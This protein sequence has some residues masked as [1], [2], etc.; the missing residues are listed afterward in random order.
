VS[1]APQAVKRL[2]VECSG[3]CRR[4]TKK[5]ARCFTSSC[6][7][8]TTN[9]RSG[10]RSATPSSTRFSRPFAGRRPT[11][12]LSDLRRRKRTTMTTRFLESA[13]PAPRRE[14]SASVSGESPRV[15]YAN[16]RFRW[17]TVVL[18]PHAVDCV[19]FCFWRRLWLFVCVWNISD[20]SDRIC[21][22]FT[23]KTCLVPRW[24]EFEGQGQFRR[25]AAC[26]LYF[27]NHLCSSCYLE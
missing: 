25:P 5:S 4:T 14:S 23:R 24:D 6:A 10:Y 21:A 19:R 26:G 7:C 12:R 17:N 13:E 15:E 27:E 18:S 8:S 20:T 1:R 22:K 9:R 11:H 16:D 3:T 2:R